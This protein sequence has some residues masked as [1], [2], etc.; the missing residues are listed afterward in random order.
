MFLRIATRLSVAMLLIT[1]GR[2]GL[3]SPLPVSTTTTLAMTSGGSPVTSVSAKTAITLTATVTANGAVESPGQVQFCDASATYCTD[4]HL[5]GLAQLNAAGVATLTFIPGVGTHHYYAQFLGTTAGATKVLASSS[6][7]VTLTV[8]GTYATTN[9]LLASG[10]PGSYTLNATVT[11]PQSTGPGGTISFVDK[12]NANYVL[13]TTSL[14]S[15]TVGV[16]FTQT[17]N[18]ATG[19][20]PVGV[21]TA[22]FNGDGIPDIATANEISNTVSVLQGKGD[23]TFSVVSSPAVGNLP[24]AVVVGDFNGDGKADL[25]VVNAGAQLLNDSWVVTILLGNGDGT[26][27]AAGNES[28]MGVGSAALCV[29]DFNGDGIADL[30]LANYDSATVSILLG[31]GDGTFK[32]P[33]IINVGR[34]PSSIATADFNNDGYADLAVTNHTDNTVS[35]LLGNGD[36]TFSAGANLAAGASPS[37]IVVADFN[38]DG[39]PDLG[40]ASGNDTVSI[41]LGNGDGTFGPA[42][43][44]ATPSIASNLAVGDFNGDGIA[45]LAVTDGY[46]SIFLGKGDGT[47]TLAD[48]LGSSAV[49]VVA[50]D[51][52]GDGITDVAATDI[53]N[54]RVVVFLDGGASSTATVTGISPVG[55]TAHMVDAVYGGAGLYSASTSNTV[56]LTAERVVTTNALT[57]NPTSSGYGQQV[58]LTGTLSPTALNITQNHTATGT[59]AFSSNG[60]SL[61]AAQTVT[62]SVASLNTTTLPAGNDN[63]SAVYSGDANFAPSTGLLPY[64]V[65]GNAIQTITF[66]QPPP[67]YVGTSVYLSAT[68]N[69]GTTITFKVVSGPAT[70]SGTTLTY[71]G[72]GSVV[73]EADAPG[74][75]TY[76]PDSA[77]DTVGVTLL[78]EPVGTS[79]A[80]VT[81]VVT[82]STAGTLAS[83]GVFTQGATGLDFVKV[84]GGSCVVGTTYMLGQSCTVEFSF[85]PTRPGQRLGGIVLSTGTG[86]M[87]ANSYIPGMGVGPQVGWLPGTQTLLGS[88]LLMPSGVAVDGSGNVYVS[89]Y[90]A[91]VA[92]IAV[93]GAQRTIG[94]FPV[95]ADVAVDGSGNLFI[96]DKTS[97]YEVVAVNGVIP[98]S[99][100]EITVLATGFSE[101]NGVA[102]SGTGNVFLANGTGSG[103]DGAVYELAAVNGV[104]STPPVQLTVGSGF[105]WVTGVAVDA[106]GNVFASDAGNKAVYEIAAVNGSVGPSSV[107]RALGGT[108]SDPSNVGLDAAND[109]YATDLATGVISEFMAVNGVV[110]AN[111]VIRTVGTGIVQPQGMVV[112]GNGN[113]F[114][115]DESISQVRKLDYADAP[116][117]TF[118]TTAVGSVSSD[119]PQTVTMANDGNAPLMFTVPGIGTNNPSI[120]TGFTIGS[121]STC[122]QLT[123]AS[124]T[125]PQ[126]STGASCTYAISFAPVTGGVDSGK[127]V[128]TDNAVGLSQTVL[129][130]GTA[131]AATMMTLTST[132]NPSGVGMSVTFTATVTSTAGVPTGSVSFADG[133]TPLGSGTLTGGVATFP[134]SSLTMGTHTITATYAGTTEFLGSSATLTQVVGYQ[135]VTTT[136][137]AP[138]P[139]TYGQPTV[140]SVHVAGAVGSTGTPTGTVQLEF[141]HG[142]TI[143]V[144]LD[145]SGSGTA[146]TPTGNEISEPAGSCPYTA[147]YLGDAFF[148]PSASASTPY[149]V[150]PANSTTTVSGAPN[151]GFVGQIVTLTAQVAGVPSPTL[152]PGGVLLP[153]GAQVAT[154]T[155]QFYD[156]ATAIGGAV[157]INAAGQASVTTSTLALGAN[158]ITAKYSGDANLNGS[159]SAG[160]IETIG[161]VPTTT[162]LNVAPSPGTQN[163]PVTMS[164]NVTALAGVMMPYGSVTIYDGTN[165]LT[166]LTLPGGSGTISSVSFT[167][168]TLAVGTHTLTA[169]YTPTCAA[170]ICS[171]LG[172]TGSQSSVVTLVILPQDF[173]LNANPPSITIETEHH[174]SMTL[175]LTSIGGFAAPITLSCAGTIPEWVTCE[176]SPQQV[177]LPAGGT[178]VPATLTIDTDALLNYKSDARGTGWGRGVVLAGLLPVMLIGFRR[179]RGLRGLAVMAV[180]SVMVMAMAACSGQYPA[181]TTPGTYTVTVQASGQTAGASAPTVHTLD[182]TLVV[183]P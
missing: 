141:C 112:D 116:S 25:A 69:A 79:S 78:T 156:G 77:Q 93:G 6:A 108:F 26:F 171:L 71:T 111:P 103:T 98:T 121:G 38:G 117:L 173:T 16:N 138:E 62:S 90:G 122:P 113:I 159:T 169:V 12:T 155:V 135:S 139:S 51:F 11:G 42:I 35:I 48:N 162:A 97:L 3:G 105:N 133:T 72:V 19:I 167:T 164:V 46:I 151:P 82:F 45:D 136:S 66:P 29:G 22:D 106:N 18:T 33:T 161:L 56:S 174:G 145:A 24:G 92:E 67:G 27:T 9:L 172:F 84:A 143:N 128:V 125:A 59:M 127:M 165:V 91:S 2:P 44:H 80:T 114:I 55:N 154:G 5:L 73:V 21:A 137:V 147:N 177:V 115:A 178:N 183:T 83:V 57:A 96:I 81:T 140:F 142:A 15:S 23:G 39:R 107:V 130:N 157:T 104:I 118:A 131:T 64:T 134:T 99:P 89:Q 152:G 179:R 54:N 144:T 8:S 163:E 61:G 181:H 158:T 63:L 31:N 126:L 95:T 30:A 65:S 85:T 129:L 47:L 150:T 149:V 20:E 132:P 109:V 10:A 160:F 74:N 166:T 14:V 102:V 75:A 13:A 7:A 28:V 53:T 68:T 40:V 37:G 41:L 175:G 70:L 86:L 43:T 180:A 176:F 76:A 50:A 101:L 52:N 1:A 87:I 32:A 119:S 60:A 182:V 94:T 170:V 148:F 36:G 88:N 124:M 100:L 49:N 168:S 4:I 34:G 58:A 123:N 153:P 120:T 110:P 17:A 146:V